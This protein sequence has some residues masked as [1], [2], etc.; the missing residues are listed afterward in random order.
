MQ[1]VKNSTSEKNLNEERRKSEHSLT[2]TMALSFW[3]SA[4]LLKLFYQNI[5]NFTKELRFHQGQKSLHKSPVTPCTL[6]RIDKHFQETSFFA[7]QAGQ[8]WK[9]LIQQ[10][11]DDVTTTVVEQTQANSNTAGV[12]SARAIS[13]Q[14]GLSQTSLQRCMQFALNAYTYKIY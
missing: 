5:N 11:I 10:L 8:G 4:L 2:T 1:V 9:T 13:R 7:V 14:L 3:Y 6:W 12:D